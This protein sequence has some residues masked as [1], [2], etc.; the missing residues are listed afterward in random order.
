MSDTSTV[1]LIQSG[2]VLACSLVWA[3][4]V[5]ATVNYIYPNNGEKLLQAQ[6][7]Y[8]VV[9]TIIVVI[10]I[11]S[12]N[13]TQTQVAK[14]ENDI[15]EKLKTIQVNKKNQKIKSSAGNLYA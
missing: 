4:T 15:L 13:K 14:V 11:Y 1:G 12:L 9:L 2:L 5:K 7:I 6:I 10:I 3:D 8:A